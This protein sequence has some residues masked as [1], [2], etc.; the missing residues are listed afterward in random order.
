MIE[1]RRT[2]LERMRHAHA[3]ALMQN[4]VRQIRELI[5]PKEVVPGQRKRRLLN[6]IDQQLPF[7]GAEKKSRSKKNA[8]PPDRAT[9]PFSIRVIL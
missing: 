3:V 9:T 4:V 2:H 6:R 8:R 7:F 5:Q 1:K